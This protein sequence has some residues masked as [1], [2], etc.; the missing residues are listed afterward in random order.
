ML[1]RF[2]PHELAGL[3]SPEVSSRLRAPMMADWMETLNGVPY[4]RQ[5]QQAD[6]DTVSASGHSGES[7]SRQYAQFAGG[8]RT[9]F[10]SSSGWMICGDAAA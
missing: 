6:L 7:G 9:I 3:L 4:L 8:A 1:R 10:G 2:Q 5:M